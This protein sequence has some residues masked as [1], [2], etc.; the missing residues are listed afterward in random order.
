MNKQTI[1][2]KIKKINMYCL[3]T[4][5]YCVPSEGKSY[6]PID[7]FDHWCVSME[8][9]Q[10]AVENATSGNYAEFETLSR[11]WW[12]ERYVLDCGQDY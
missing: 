10:D 5:A 8:V 1:T 6:I 3:T 9:P 2:V 7:N 11:E 4:Y 12:Q